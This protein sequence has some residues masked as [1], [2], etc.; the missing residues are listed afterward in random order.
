MRQR[1]S[2]RGLGWTGLAQ[3][4]RLVVRLT[5]NGVPDALFTQPMTFKAAVHGVASQADG[6]ILA[7]G[8]FDLP[9]AHIARLRVNATLDLQFDPGTGA[10][11]AVNAVALQPDGKI[12]L[13]GAFTNVQGFT[14]HRLARLGTNGVLDIMS[15]NNIM[16]RF[17]KIDKLTTAT[18]TQDPTSSRP[19]RFGYGVYDENKNFKQDENEKKVYFEISDYATNYVFYENP[20]DD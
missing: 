18:A 20:F 16:H 14:C 1:A 19:F 8:A 12:L 17:I 3:A 5:S 15:G 4:L 13:G 9:L 6:K 11:A 10:D 2:L 7:G